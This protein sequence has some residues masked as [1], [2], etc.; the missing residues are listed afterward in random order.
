MIESADGKTISE[1]DPK[2]GGP[3]PLPNDANAV[4]KVDTGK[5][6]IGKTHA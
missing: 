6:I 1:T 5:K 3:L 4:V 2:T